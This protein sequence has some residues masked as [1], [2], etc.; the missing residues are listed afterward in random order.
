MN[1]G[2]I[3]AMRKILIIGANSA[4]ARCFIATFQQTLGE[5]F[6]CDLSDSYNEEIA[7]AWYK[8]DLAS[9]AE[10]REVIKAVKPDHI[11]NFAGTFSNNYEIDYQANVLLPKNIFDAILSLDFHSR[12]L[13]IGSSAEYGFVQEQDN[14][15]TEE[16]SLRPVSIYGLTKAFQTHLMQYY[17]QAKGIDA[18][19]ARTFNL[20]SPSMSEKLFVGRLYK[21]I[22]QF[23][24]GEIEKIVLG[25]LES[26]RDYIEV[27]EAVKQYANIMNNGRSGEVYN[28]GSGY[29][30][31]I[32]QLLR[33]ILSENGLCME[34]VQTVD[35]RSG[36]EVTDIFAD[37]SKL[38]NIG[39]KSSDCFTR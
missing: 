1:S 34:N 32:A 9:S 24:A 15:I 3:D 5:M 35:C 14:P 23:K 28:V 38:K 29:S 2:W 16:H 33:Q 30:I 37:I 13:L 7:N 26:K 25:N 4:T 18:V 39:D 27:E 11:Y 17:V 12:V 21:Q 20:H 36:P 22:A 6:F 10:I 19:M 8:C 31:Q